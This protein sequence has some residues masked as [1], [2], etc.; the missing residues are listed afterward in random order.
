MRKI[1]RSFS[2]HTKGTAEVIRPKQWRSMASP[3]AGGNQFLVGEKFIVT[4]NKR[5]TACPIEPRLSPV[6]YVEQLHGVVLCQPLYHGKQVQMTIGYVESNNPSGT[7][8]GLVDSKRLPGK[9][10]NWYGIPGKCING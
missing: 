2:K 5:P 8:M 9:Q 3:A 10:V 4:G 1:Q 7:D 6:H